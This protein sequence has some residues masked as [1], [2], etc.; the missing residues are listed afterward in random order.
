MDGVDHG[1]LF[2]L[3]R[4]RLLELLGD[5]TPAEW[6]RPTP[7]PAWDVAGLCRHL[8]GDDLHLIALH[9]D[10]HLGARPPDGADEHGFIAWLDELQE[11]WVTAAARLSPRLV[12][13]LLA[14]CAPQVA[15]VIGSG[16][17]DAVTARV[18]WA[19]DDLVPVWLDRARELSEY[20]IHR[21]QL[22]EA[23]GRTA[24]H[25]VDVL[26]PVLDGLRWAYPYRLRQVAAGP[27][28]TVVI[29]VRGDVERIWCIVRDATGWTFAD[30]PAGPVIARAVLSTDQTWR[31]L[32]NNLPPAELDDLDL[33]GAPPV[34]EV[35]RRTRA[36]IGEPVLD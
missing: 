5:L 7:C 17:P 6:G 13:D 14:W 3:E 19:G 35:L 16:D 10:G 4:A 23:L 15:D 22:L 25:R 1:R 2:A 11:G 8:L 30:E 29:E 31:L 12:V 28:D 33:S 34:L 21:Q 36:I 18:S 26:G 9:R 24:D 20:W 27:G 32:T